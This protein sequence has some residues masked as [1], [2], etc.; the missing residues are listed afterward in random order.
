[1][2][3]TGRQATVRA[4]DD[5]LAV[6]VR[7]VER[8]GILRDT[9]TTLACLIAAAIPVVAACR[10]DVAPQASAPSTTAALGG[11]A[12]AEPAIAGA[13]ST[14]PVGRVV[15]IGPGPEGVVVARSGIGAVAVRNPDGIELFDATT[16]AVSRRIPLEGA[17]RHISLAGPDGPVLVP[18]EGSNELV[19]LDLAQGAVLDG[20]AVFVERIDPKLTEVARIDAPGHPYGPAYDANRK[21]LYVTL[22]A[23]N[24]LRV[25]DLSDVTRPRVVG[26]V[27]VVQQPNSVA[28]E[29]HS[30][31]ILIAGVGPAGRGSLQIVSPTLLP[32]G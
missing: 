26:D 4:V 10:G 21:R 2:P 11:T 28:V 19:Q 7:V 18:L 9:R 29:P 6:P 23:S 1:M 5:D 24:L 20:G 22:T 30:G 15:A 14:P 32:T 13:P 31:D 3:S 16:G 8:K 27:A 17:A 12:P 25:I